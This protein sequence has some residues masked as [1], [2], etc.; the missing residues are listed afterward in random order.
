MIPGFLQHIT[1]KTET[2][3]IVGEHVRD[4]AQTVASLPSKATGKQCDHL[5]LL[6]LLFFS[7]ATDPIFALAIT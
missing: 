7:A 2:D 3:Q 6:T 1:Q 5:Q 4:A